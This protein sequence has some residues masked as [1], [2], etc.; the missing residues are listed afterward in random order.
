[1]L[2]YIYM[3]YVTF[4]FPSELLLQTTTSPQHARTLPTPP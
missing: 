3:Q 4:S 2:G 1:L